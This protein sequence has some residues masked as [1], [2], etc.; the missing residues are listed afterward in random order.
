MIRLYEYRLPFKA[1]FKTAS[2]TY[3]HRTGILIDYTTDEFSVL[4]E[5]SPLPGFSNDTF[6]DVKKTFLQIENNLNLFFHQDFD[7]QK[8]KSFLDTLPDLPSLQFSLSYLG[9]ALLARR[10]SASIA[11]IMGLTPVKSIQVNEIIGAGHVSDIEEKIELGLKNGF[12]TFK[13]KAPYPVNTLA[14]I[15]KTICTAYPSIKIRLDANQSWPENK[16]AEIG[17]VL[18]SLPIEFIEEPVAF[19]NPDD[20]QHIISKLSVPV[21]VDESIEGITGLNSFL[22]TGPELF[23][24]IKPMILGNL[25]RIHETISKYRSNH[26]NV[27]VTTSLESVVGRSMITNVATVIGDPDLAHGLNTGQFF[28]SDLTETHPDLTGSISYSEWSETTAFS[29]I[30]PSKITPLC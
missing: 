1:P 25:F 19:Q 23:V 22:K 12:T 6:E 26:T 7:I 4:S 27:V 11:S 24:I 29:K 5:A 9:I 30:N 3:D 28:N 15:L 18:Q 14:D 20:I 10:K 8:L 17:S 2:N 21:A 13:F 16:I